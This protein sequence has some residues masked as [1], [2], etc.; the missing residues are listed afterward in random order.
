MK[1]E[2]LK[3]KIVNILTNE[4]PRFFDG[5][6]VKEIKDLLFKNYNI[7]ASERII[8]KVMLELTKFENEE[9]YGFLCGD[10]TYLIFADDHGYE[11]SK[12]RG[13]HKYRWYNLGGI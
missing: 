7:S 10:G 9:E 2:E 11:E 13:V 3:T 8:I 5:V 4:N 6:S 12:M 1:A